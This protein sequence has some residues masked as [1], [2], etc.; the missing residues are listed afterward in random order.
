[1]AKALL[2][3]DIAGE[4]TARVLDGRLPADARVNEVRLAGEL[5]VSRTPLRE[6]LIGLADHGLLVAAP[7]R[8][9]LVPPLDPAEAG[10]LYPLVAELEALAVRW[11]SLLELA[12]LTDELDRCA[13]EMQTALD[14]GEELSAL[15]ERWHGLLLSRCA[16]PHLLRLIVQTKPLLKRY[17]MHYFRAPERAARSIEEHRRITAAIRDGDL[18]EATRWLVRNWGCPSFE[19]MSFEG[20]GA[21]K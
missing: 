2:R 11:T 3:Q 18:A 20:R 21:K 7:G 1:M 19:G 15:D 6:V 5:G 10:R 12:G 8:G 4:V 17:E 16:N 9:F 13:D 14:R